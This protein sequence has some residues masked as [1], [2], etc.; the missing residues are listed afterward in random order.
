FKMLNYHN[1]Y[2]SQTLSIK[3]NDYVT[4]PVLQQCFKVMKILSLHTVFQ[5][6]FRYGLALDDGGNHGTL[7]CKMEG[8]YIGSLNASVIVSTPYGRT[9]ADLD[10][11]HVT[12]NNKIAMF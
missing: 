11:L 5:I 2:I 10:M 4:R 3:V 12:S 8:T 9:Q 6:Y 7:K 1:I